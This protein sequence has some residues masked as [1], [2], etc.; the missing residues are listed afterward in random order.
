MLSFQLIII[1]LYISSQVCKI[2][3]IFGNVHCYH[4]WKP[5]DYREIILFTFHFF[6]T[7]F[8]NYLFTALQLDKD[9]PFLYM[10]L[11]DE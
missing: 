1:Y 9:V 7:L 5:T 10:H 6:L 8:A 3:T 4:H 2:F 11:V